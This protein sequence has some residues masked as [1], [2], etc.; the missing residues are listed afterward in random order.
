MTPEEKLGNLIREYR[1]KRGLLLQD[2]G[3]KVDVNYTHIS[4][5][6]KGMRA[7]SDEL[8]AKLA[9][10][11]AENEQEE[12]ELRERF[13]F[14]LAQIKAPKEIRNK[15]KLKG[16]REV[17]KEE[18]IVRGPMP[19]AFL[20]VLRKDVAVRSPEFFDNAGIPYG[21]IR[22]VLEGEAWLSREEVIKLAN[23][24]GRNVN[25]YLVKA[26][27]IPQE[28]E[29]MLGRKS[30]VELMRSLKKLPPESMDKMISAIETILKTLSKEDESARD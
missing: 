15:L 9:H 27:Y 2:L 29:N 17:K 4:Y 30:V 26:E 23:L 7:P 8:L 16:E 18:E 3:K 12:K 25:E 11:L 6:E 13:F 5:I 19:K 21:F 22:K 14:Y 20:D 10:E 24:M 1:E 28:F